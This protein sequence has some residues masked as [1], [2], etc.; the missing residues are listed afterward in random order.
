MTRSHLLLYRE[1]GP[2]RLRGVT[3][4]LD[5]LEMIY[6]TSPK[7]MTHHP[8]ATNSKATL[9]KVKFQEN[10]NDIQNSNLTA[11]FMKCDKKH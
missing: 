3:I 2:C 10:G 5:H 1:T 9:N 4:P 7:G 6:K 8:A 11:Q